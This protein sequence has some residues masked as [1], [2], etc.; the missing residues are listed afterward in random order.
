MVFKKLDSGCTRQSPLGERE[1]LCRS[2]SI[3]STLPASERSGRRT[4]H[5]D[6]V[7]IQIS[8]ALSGKKLPPFRPSHLAQQRGEIMRITLRVHKQ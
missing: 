3:S 2:V 4:S 8:K 7:D 1:I 5:G 6:A